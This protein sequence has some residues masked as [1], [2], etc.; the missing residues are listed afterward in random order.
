VRSTP[1]VFENPVLQHFLIIAAFF[2]ISASIG[3]WAITKY[4]IYD[5]ATG[6]ADGDAAQ[7]IKMSR[8]E[9]L[10]TI[11]KPFRYR[12]VIP[13]I[14]GKVPTTVPGGELYYDLTEDK[15]VALQFGIVNIFG[16]TATAYLLFVS[17]SALGLG[18]FVSALASLIFLTSFNTVNFTPVPLVDAWAY[19]TLMGGVYCIQR[20][21]YVAL[22]TLSLGAVF[23]K[24]TYLLML[25]FAVII[26]DH[27]K[28]KLRSLSCVVPALAAYVYFRA[29]LLPTEAGY[30]YSLEIVL[31][32]IVSQFSNAH[33][34]AALVIEGGQSFGIWWVFF[35]FYVLCF[36]AEHRSITRNLII[37]PIVMVVPFLTYANI[38]RIWFMAFPAVIPAAAYAIGRIFEPRRTAPST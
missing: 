28:Q 24:E 31:D 29:F 16:I 15:K 26:P 35:A 5:G 19:A 23:V 4:D 18:V 33:R 7:Y 8:G 17:C 1:R 36:R 6:G 3:Y 38:G 37:L 12:V 14:A 21:W 34:A 25:F 11:P 27:M 13:Y 32:N 20:K 2:W 22:T 30:N 10:D 9:S